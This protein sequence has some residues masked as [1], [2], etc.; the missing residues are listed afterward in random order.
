MKTEQILLAITISECGSITKAAQKLYMAQPN[1]SNA[2]YSL[3]KELGYTIFE[4]SPNGIQV[5]PKGEKFLQYAHSIQR[6]IDNINLLRNEKEKIRLFVATYAYSFAENAF[7]KFCK[8]YINSAETMDCNLRRIG[9]I[10]EGMD[11]LV[12]SYSDVSVIVCNRDL[13][14]YFSKKFKQKNLISYLLGYT[15]LHLT[16][17]ESHPLAQK[18]SFNLM[19][20]VG[21][22]CITNAGITLNYVPAEIENL[23]NETQLH[24]VTD[25]GETR[26]ALLKNSNNY[27][28]STPYSKNFLEKYHLVSKEIPHSDRCIIVLIREEDQK[29]KQI[30]RYIELIQNEFPQWGSS[31]PEDIYS[32]TCIDS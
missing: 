15:T 11:M 13:L 31:L 2:L 17:S 20:F 16:M 22:P 9:T 10:K 3:E 24:I 1:A 28:I 8:E 14:G 21:Y 4:R 6:N 23:L 12:N 7:V 29:N 19:D 26:V 25:P 5:T 30:L 32:F 27:S 18:E